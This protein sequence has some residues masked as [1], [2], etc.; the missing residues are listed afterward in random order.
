MILKNTT[1]PR[2]TTIIAGLAGLFSLGSS[3]VNA[4]G[5]TALTFWTVRLNTP[6]LAEALRGILAEFQKAYPSIKITHE[7]VSGGLVYPKF[8][9]AVRGQTMPD[10]AEA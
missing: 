4:Q 5:Q 6:E 3:G 9:A 1:I 10:V 8:L 7:P 2:R